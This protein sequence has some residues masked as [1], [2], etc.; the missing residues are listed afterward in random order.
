MIQDICLEYKV[1]Y[2]GKPCII[3]ISDILKSIS[4]TLLSIKRYLIYYVGI[5]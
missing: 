5:I 4:D 3:Y 2:F 1:F